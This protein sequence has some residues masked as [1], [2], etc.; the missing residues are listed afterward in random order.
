M[1]YEL[2]RPLLF[3]LD[4]EVAH[5]LGMRWLNVMSS[6]MK[7]ESPLLETKVSFGTLRNPLG[8]AAGFDKTGQW[9][10]ALSRL[11]FGYMVLGTVTPQPKQGHPRP[12]IVRR[13]QE[14]ALVNAMGFPNQG[15]SRFIDVITK[16]KMK[17]PILASISG[18]TIDDIVT[19]YR[20][21]QPV[22][23][24]VE[25]NLSSPNTPALADLREEGPLRELAEAIRNRSTKPTF[26][27]LQP[28]INHDFA[29]RSMR[30]ASIW[31]NA[32]LHGV[33]CSNA[34]PVE[35]SR[36]STGTGGLS[37]APLYP[38]TLK[39]VQTLRRTLGSDFEIHAVG[40]VS[41]A[42]QMLELRAAGANTVQIFSAIVYEG[43]GL[44]RRIL[45]DAV[46]LIS[47]QPACQTSPLDQLA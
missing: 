8:L 25:V 44:I 5:Y 23:S 42:R 41:N 11:G 21:V 1:L 46:K 10:E 36:V 31:C 29:Q 3:S 38:Y 22:V 18:E 2:V 7:D 32:G 30:A 19:C 39:A 35:E 28:F 40:G 34:I 47:D 37:G 43:P 9:A 15:I 13:Q 24:G 45:R 27:K 17:I 4:P 26:L 16:L 6:E 12:R 20:M 33:T 14:R